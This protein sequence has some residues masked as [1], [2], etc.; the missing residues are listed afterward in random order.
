MDLI[1][2]SPVVYIFR[3][4]PMR[5]S[6]VFRVGDTDRDT[7]KSQCAGCCRVQAAQR[8]LPT[9]PAWLCDGKA[10]MMAITAIGCT[11][12]GFGNGIYLTGFSRS[13]I[14][15]VCSGCA[16]NWAMQA[17]GVHHQTGGKGCC[18]LTPCLVLPQVM[19]YIRSASANAALVADRVDRLISALPPAWLASSGTASLVECLTSVARTMQSSSKQ[20]RLPTISPR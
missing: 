17:A 11:V 2:D 13:L 5:I 6:A 4:S 10:A 9:V 12:P 14:S 19:S 15:V 8:R 1:T 16:L 3:T 20:V 18:W 7:S